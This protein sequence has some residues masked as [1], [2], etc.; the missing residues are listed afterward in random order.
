L[1]RAGKRQVIGP[2]NARA[3]ADRPAGIAGQGRQWLAGRLNQGG[4]LET[5]YGGD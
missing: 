2:E 1:V 4:F 5:G 3:P